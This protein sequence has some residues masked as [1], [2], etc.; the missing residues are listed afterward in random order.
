M[1]TLA[2]LARIRTELGLAP[3][4]GVLRL[5]GRAATQAQCY[6]H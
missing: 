6:Q 2:D 4:D 3:A 1:T 5:G